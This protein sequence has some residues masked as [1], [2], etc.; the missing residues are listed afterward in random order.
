MNKKDFTQYINAN[1]KMYSLE[2]QIK[3]LEKMQSWVLELIHIKQKK[4]GLWVESSEKSK[5]VYCEKC[6]KYYLKEK[7]KSI[8]QTETRIVTTYS[9]CGYGDDDKLGEV[10]ESVHYKPCPRCG[11]MNEMGRY[12]IRVIKEWP[13]R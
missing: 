10:E 11:H 3:I 4:V 12:R 9:D 1:L 6:K 2:K 13:R 8:F 5:Y 7:V